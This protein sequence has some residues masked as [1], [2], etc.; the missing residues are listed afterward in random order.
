[1]LLAENVIHSLTFNQN[2]KPDSI[3]ASTKR[4]TIHRSVQLLFLRLLWNIP[5]VLI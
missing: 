3:R 5:A 2:K 4:D 1:M